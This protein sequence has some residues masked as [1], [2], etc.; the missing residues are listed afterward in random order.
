MII[1][2]GDEHFMRQALKEAEQAFKV[3]EVPVGAVIV[4]A[5]RIIARG[6]NLTERLNDVTAHAE[7]QSITAAAEHLGGKYLKDCTLYVTLEP[8]V[9]CAGAL[10]WSQLGRMVFGAFDEKAGYR[11]IGG[12]LLHPKTQVTGGVLEAECSDLLKA[13]FKRKRAL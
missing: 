7:M 13:F 5:D 2:T 4:C 11:R 10:H 12:S 6:H 1:Q 8:C 9:M 3:D